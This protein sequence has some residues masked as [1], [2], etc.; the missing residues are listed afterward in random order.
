MKWLRFM[1][2]E[3]ARAQKTMLTYMLSSLWHGFY[4]GYYITFVSG[5]FFTIVARYVSLSVHDEIRIFSL[6]LLGK[7]KYF[8]IL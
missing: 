1:V 8:T 6:C 2:Y 3:R 7:L 4:P 5:A